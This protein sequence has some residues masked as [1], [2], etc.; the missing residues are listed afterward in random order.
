MS[1]IK[2]TTR[3]RNLVELTGIIIFVLT[4]LIL[5]MLIGDR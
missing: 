3:G 1:K 4:P 5:S 2:L